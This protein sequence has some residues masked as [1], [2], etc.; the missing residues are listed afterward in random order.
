ML[1]LLLTPTVFHDHGVI[2]Y[3]CVPDV[4]TIMANPWCG[5]GAMHDHGDIMFARH[6][7]SCPQVS[8]PARHRKVGRSAPRLF[9]LMP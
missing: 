3:T 8:N 2:M 7:G 4:S 6:R 1:H 9:G 5:R